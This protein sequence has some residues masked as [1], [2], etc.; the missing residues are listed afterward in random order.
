MKNGAFNINLLLALYFIFDVK[1]SFCK[2]QGLSGHGFG[3]LCA[4]QHQKS[5]TMFTN[6]KKLR[7]G[8]F[9]A[10]IDKTIN[11]RCVGKQ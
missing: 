2:M 3:Q 7:E 11:F 1:K 8:F 9:Y 6:K 5:R 4:Q 10:L